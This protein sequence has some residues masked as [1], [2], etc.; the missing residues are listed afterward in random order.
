MAEFCLECFNQLNETKLTEKEVVLQ[1]DLCEGCGLIKPCVIS[2]YKRPKMPL[3]SFLKW[4]G[5]E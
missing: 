2:I 4:L 5:I 3:K 1:E